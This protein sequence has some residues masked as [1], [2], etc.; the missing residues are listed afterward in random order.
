M[1]N[2]LF[3]PK[4]MSDKELTNNLEK[5]QK[6]SAQIY[7]GTYNK[8]LIDQINN[9][10]DQCQFEIEERNYLSLYESE[11]NNETIEI[12]IENNDT[13]ENKEDKKPKR[14][15][16]RVLKTSTNEQ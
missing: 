3:N 12:G 2:F 15:R 16:R 6:R 10:L 11:H 14:R 5:L 8:Q 9:Y 4:K 1:D 13:I 7:N